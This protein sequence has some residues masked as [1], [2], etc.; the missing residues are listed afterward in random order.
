MD[1]ISSLPPGVSTVIRST[2][3]C[4]TIEPEPE[5]ECMRGLSDVGLK[6]TGSAIE[7]MLWFPGQVNQGL[8]R[9]GLVEEVETGE[10]KQDKETEEED[11]EGEEVKEEEEEE[12]EE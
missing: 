11:K 1:Y 4:T 5:S 8:I 12:E 3:Q 2:L 7:P 9:P 6:V 10:E